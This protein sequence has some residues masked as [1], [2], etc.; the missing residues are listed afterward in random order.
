MKTEAECF[1]FEFDRRFEIYGERFV[2]FDFNEPKNFSPKFETFFDFIIADPPFLSKICLQKIAE[3]INFV[4]KGEKK[5]IICTG[6]IL[7]PEIQKLFKANPCDFIP[8]H[9]SK[10]ANEFR[11]FANYPTQTFE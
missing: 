3:T 2:F 11:C 6:A 10:L 4:A 1:L 5:L 7:A 9:A 8:R